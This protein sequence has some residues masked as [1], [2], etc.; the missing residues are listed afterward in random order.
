MNI[1]PSYLIEHC[2]LIK[3]GVLTAEPKPPKQLLFGISANCT[4]HQTPS[5][6]QKYLIT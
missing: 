4:Y 6:L 2:I 3:V 5:E 1:L